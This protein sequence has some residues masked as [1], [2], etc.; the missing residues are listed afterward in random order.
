MDLASD[1][2]FSEINTTWIL[3]EIYKDVKK[4]NKKIDHLEIPVCKF[5]KD[6]N[7]HLRNRSTN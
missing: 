3:L 6:Q 7:V 4:M 5:L 2:N 1:D